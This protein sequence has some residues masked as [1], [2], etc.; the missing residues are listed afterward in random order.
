MSVTVAVKD[1][2]LTLWKPVIPLTKEL[3]YL[4]LHFKDN[5]FQWW[6]NYVFFSNEKFGSFSTEICILC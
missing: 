1:S 3:I 4:Y 5:F 6:V 2:T